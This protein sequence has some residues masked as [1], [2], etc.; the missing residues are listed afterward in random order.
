M[1]RRWTEEESLCLRSLVAQNWPLPFLP[2]ALQKR[3]RRGRLYT[4]EEVQAQAE[5]LGI[6]L[7]PP[8]GQDTKWGR[9]RK[10]DP[11]RRPLRG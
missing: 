10:V 11:W 5:K 7:G 8:T 3:C 6:A 9:R 4:V 2:D 1:P